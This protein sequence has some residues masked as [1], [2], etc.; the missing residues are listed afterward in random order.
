M[1]PIYLTVD[2]IAEA[3]GADV[4]GD[5]GATI[6]GIASIESAG[7]ED[8]TFA[9]DKRR[10]D[11]LADCAAGAALVE[12]SAE[13]PAGM[14]ALRVADPQAALAKV[15][16]LMAP[17]D[18]LPAPGAHPTAVIDPE[19]AL[20]ADVAIGP[21]AVIGAGATLGDRVVLAANVSVGAGASLGDDTVLYPGVVVRRGCRIGRRCRVH[22]NAVIGADGFG[23]Y[24][25]DGVHHKVPHAGTVVVGDD[26]EIGACTC[27]DRAKFG[28]TVIG[29]GSKIDNL[30]QI[31]HNVQL[32]RGVLAA[33]LVG[34]AGSTRIGDYVMLG[35]HVGIRDNISI[36]DGARIGAF[37]GV[38]QDVEPRA[39][40]RGNIALPIQQSLRAHKVYARLPELW[41]QF[42]QLQARVDALE[43]EPDNAGA[44]G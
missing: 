15:L 14:T 3:I 9:L 42:R 44:D 41:R 2:R 40:M 16:G 43:N 39:A 33:S 38:A 31:A 34:V 35:G 29:D 12:E 28:A 25:D 7:P 23:Y 21:H 27:I 19:A 26:V 1:D 37:S 18:D 8:L 32:G 36:G 5:G 11:R 20:G 30:V 17:P 6:R 13:V 24:H 10:A 4:D 22:P